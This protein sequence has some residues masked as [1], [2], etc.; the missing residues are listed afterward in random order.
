[1]SLMQPS[2][3]HL[4]DLNAKYLVP[5]VHRMI[6][7]KTVMPQRSLRKATRTW[8]EWRKRKRRILIYDS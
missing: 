3:G 2:H 4:F 1:M 7:E 5:S 8:K 6:V